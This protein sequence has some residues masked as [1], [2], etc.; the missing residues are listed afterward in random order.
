MHPVLRRAPRGALAVLGF[1]NITPTFSQPFISKDF[2]R[3][4]RK[5]CRV[6]RSRYE[7]V[8]MT[9]GYRRL[10]NGDVPKKP[11]LALAFDDGYLD[12]FST[13]MPIMRDAGGGVILNISTYAPDVG[14]GGIEAPYAI[15]KGGL[16]T[17][18]RCCAYEGGLHNI[19][20]CTVSMGMVKGTRFAEQNPELFDMPESQ[21]VLGDSYPT[22]EEIAEAAAF[23]ASDKARNITGETLNVAAGAYM[24]T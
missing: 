15:T 6:L 18:T 7:M 23:L 13:I 3:R 4:F 5:L 17:L 24:R 1:H 21:G 12:T 19:R 8:T 9:E 10:V 22:A 16:N 20:A 14:G 2:P 11:L